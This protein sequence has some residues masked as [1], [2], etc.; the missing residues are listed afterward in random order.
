MKVGYIRFNPADTCELPRVEH[1][2][3]KPLDNDAIG[4]FVNAVRGHKFEDVFLVTLFTGMRRGEVLGMTWDCVDFN[5]GT[6]HIYKQLQKIPDSGGKYH[7]ISTKNSKGRTI[8]PALSV[9]ELLRK[10]RALQN[11]MKLKAGQLWQD[12]NFVFTDEFG[13]H[14]MPHTVYHN[15]KKIVSSI[16]L[17]ESRF[18]DLRH[19]YAVAALQSGDDVKTV[20]QNLGH[21][22]AAFTL[23]V[24]AHVTEQMKKDSAE[25]MEQFIKSVSS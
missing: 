14:L 18:H 13:N 5:K 15:Y 21:H 1:K 2:D 20:Q 19:S 6:I 11:E 16:G 8:T 25:R 10:H 24:Y 7:L 9:I 17:P 23:D 4:A 12:S 3:I 22:A